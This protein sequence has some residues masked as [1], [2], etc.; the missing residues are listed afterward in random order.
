MKKY[1]RAARKNKKKIQLEH[2]FKIVQHNLIIIKDR[3]QQGL[4][5]F[6]ESSSQECG[7]PSVHIYIKTIFIHMILPFIEPCF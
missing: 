3:I 2:L 4:L 7:T 1:P 6:L 5:I